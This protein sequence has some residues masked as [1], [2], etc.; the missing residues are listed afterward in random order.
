MQQ[1]WLATSNQ[2][3]LCTRRAVVANCG[4]Q[5]AIEAAGF[6][7]VFLVE[8][9][10]GLPA[11]VLAALENSAAGLAHPCRSDQRTQRDSTKQRFM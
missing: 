7:A 2:S 10:L 1:C 3:V 5:L 11:A 8:A 4:C 9:G 6:V